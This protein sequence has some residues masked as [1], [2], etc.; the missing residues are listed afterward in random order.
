MALIAQMIARNESDR[1][2]RDVLEHLTK[3][4][5]RVVFTDDCSDDDTL[6]VAKEFTD[7]TYQTPEP[8]FSQHEGQLRQL[9]WEN[10]NLHAKPGDWV[11]AIDADEKLYSREPNGIEAVLHQDRYDVV[12]I[13]FY[14]MW[15]EN[16][17]RKDKAW[18][19]HGSTRLFR[20]RPNGVF[21][22]RKMACGSEPTYVKDMIANRKFL[23]TSP[24]AMQ[25]LGYVRDED[26]RMKYDRYMALDQGNF[27]N[28]AHIISIIDPNPTL[29]NWG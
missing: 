16:Q 25:H 1:F 11:L 5:D 18:A 7:F 24:L 20:Y 14:H 8:M 19:P 2:L 17:Y 9:A 23:K 15:N 29:E 28:L 6:T 21:A 4:A 22:N 13:T 27:H 26:K 3:F 10:L 12:N